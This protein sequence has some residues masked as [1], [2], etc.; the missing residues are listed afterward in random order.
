MAIETIHRLRLRGH[1]VHI[2]DFGTGYSS[3][4]YLQDLSVDAIKID[5]SFTQSI[6]TGAVTM[7]I[8]PQILAMAE[9]L[10]L[11]VIAEGIETVEQAGYFATAKQPVLAQGWLFGRPVPAKRFYRALAENDQETAAGEVKRG[12]M[13]NV[14]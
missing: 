10:D 11:H 9:A 6:G 1:S 2:D 7:A 13:A 12:R 8:L 5:R 3:L 4:S 14:A